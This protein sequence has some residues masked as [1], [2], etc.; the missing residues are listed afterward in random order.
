[1]LVELDPGKRQKIVHQ[2]AHPLRLRAHHLEETVGR[3]RVL[4]GR[5][6]QRL[7]APQQQPRSGF[8]ARGSHWRRNPRG[9]GRGSGSRSRR[10]PRSERP[11]RPARGPEARRCGPPVRDRSPRS[12]SRPPPAL[13][14]EMTRS[15]ASRTPGS[16][17]AATRSAP[18]G[19]TPRIAVEPREART[20][21]R[22]PS[23]AITGSGR[24]SSTV[25][26]DAPLAARSPRRWCRAAVE[27][28]NV[29]AN[30]RE[31][32]GD[33]T[34][35]RSGA[36]AA[37]MRFNRSAIRAR[38]DRCRPTG[39][40]SAATTATAASAATPNAIS[41]ASARISSTPTKG[42]ARTASAQ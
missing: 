20:I 10:S 27:S 38:P 7:D 14:V 18:T 42:P 30:L 40:Q 39:S 29:D 41:P 17:T 25:S 21:R 5:A 13:L 19:S 1:M 4:P 2:P 16:R 37:S 9:S 6:A 11:C 31:S 15:A 33:S 28:A 3:H 12:G 35:S 36:L 8:S 22:S 24:L 23:I 32:S 26:A 34:C